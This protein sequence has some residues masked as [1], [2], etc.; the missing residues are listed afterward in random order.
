MKRSPSQ[1]L[2]W[3]FMFGFLCLYITNSHADVSTT[4]PAEDPNT[5][6]GHNPYQKP[7]PPAEH[8]R[9]PVTPYYQN[10]YRRPN[11]PPPYAEMT[12]PIETQS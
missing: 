10:P 9:R 3:V 7:P 6:H 11:P 12:V 2:L 8:G 4:P 5:G 1:A